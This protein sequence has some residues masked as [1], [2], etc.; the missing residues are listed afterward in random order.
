MIKS[1]SE[2]FVSMDRFEVGNRSVSDVVMKAIDEKKPV[3]AMSFHNG[4]QNFDYSPVESLVIEDVVTKAMRLMFET[5][6]GLLHM[7]TTDADQKFFTCG[8]GFIEAARIAAMD[9]FLDSRGF[10]CKLVIKENLGISEHRMARVEVAYNHSMF[11]ND[12][13]VKA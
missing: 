1:D 3:F 6:S 4:F 13:L 7:L 5:P 11:V 12:I 8:R 9:V 2:M 10:R